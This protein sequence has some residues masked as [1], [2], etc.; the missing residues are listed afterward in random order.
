MVYGH[1]VETGQTVPARFEAVSGLPS[2][3]LGQQGTCPVQ[4]LELLR[5]KA[6]GLRPRYVFLC[7]H[8]TDVMDAITAYDPGE[9][10]RF[11]E[12]DG[13]RPLARAD[14]ESGVFQY[15][16]DHAA[17]PLRAARV[18]RGVMHPAEAAFAPAVA[19]RDDARFLPAAEYVAEP[20]APLA[21][22]GS[23][24]AKRGWRVFRRAIAQIQR[25]CERIGARLVLFDIG[26]PTAFS[27]AVE[28]LAREAGARYSDA[29]R[30]VLAAARGGEDVYLPHDGHW[31]PAGCDAVARRLAVEVNDKDDH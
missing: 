20:F 7:A 19:P 18:V 4:A 25:E 28:A 14:D 17:I 8:P 31:S 27:A 12:R 22:G 30:V 21:A 23:P 13:Y 10:E 15:W 26:Y 11:L 2:A 3:N 9:L 6:L 1:G 24:D 5:R 29:G 16:L